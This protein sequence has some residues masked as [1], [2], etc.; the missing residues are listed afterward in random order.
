MSFMLKVD[1][2]T[3]NIGSY[4]INKYK[5]IK[6]LGEGNFSFVYLVQDNSDSKKHFVLKEFFPHGF[7][8]REKNNKIF[9]KKSLTPWKIDEYYDLKKIFKKESE[10]LK[11]VNKA[12]HAGIINFISYHEN[13]NNTSYILTDYIKTIPLKNHIKQLTPQLL[14]KLLNELL[15]TLEHIH[16]YNIYHQDIK[17]QNILI[18]KDLTP[19]LIDFGGSAILYDKKTGEYLN[20]ASTDSAALE[21]LSLNYPPEI[22]KSTDVYSVAVL[23]YK[24]LTGN[25][26]INAK[27]REQAI[28][29]GNT[30]PYISLSSKKLSCFQRH[31]L[32]AID[33][34][35]NL[36]VED[37]YNDTKEFRLAL[38][39]NNFWYQIKIFL[40]IKFHYPWLD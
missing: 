14:I 22:N 28:E 26:P 25:Y 18:K 19:L 16:F 38:N 39:K 1:T 15:L 23:M 30:D 10:N 32:L 3:L 37:R 33:K 20:T 29:R 9:I 36:Y 31:T 34:A 27:K 7:V 12:K 4:I 40:S 6:L 8:E 13:I 5:I 11:Q 17:L 24:I 2:R 35:L 21:Q